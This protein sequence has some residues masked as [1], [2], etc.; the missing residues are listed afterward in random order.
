MSSTTTFRQ[1]GL[2]TSRSCVGPRL[3][4]ALLALWLVALSAFSG[5]AAD[6]G[7]V[8]FTVDFPNSAPEHYSI[9]VQGDGRASYESSGRISLDSDERDTYQTDFVFSEPAR[10]RIFQLAAQAHHFSGKIDSGNKKLAFT[11]AKKL[12][13]S[14]GQKNSSAEYNYSSQPAV[15]QLTTLFQTVGATLEYGHRLSYFHKYQKLALDDEL[16]RMEE[17]ARNGEITELQAVK[18]VLQGIYDDSSVM[19]VDRARALRIM[20]MPPASSAGNQARR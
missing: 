10:V 6:S 15:Q 12:T 2:F 5:T 18:P 7:S 9:S 19:N 1:P 20:E 16:K 4:L 17:Q 13:Y 11:G 3:G 8:T 14:D